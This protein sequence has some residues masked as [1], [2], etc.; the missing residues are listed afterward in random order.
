MA[1]SPKVALALA[2]ARGTDQQLA[3]AFALLA[4]R[5]SR[6]A[7]VRDEGTLM[8][9]WS[10]KHVAALQPAIQKYGKTVSERPELLR[11][12]LLSGTRVGAFGLLLDLKDMALLVQEM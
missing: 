10:A 3:Q 2:I 6:E 4:D 5:H 11:A 1:G 7:D 12:A 8:A 9:G